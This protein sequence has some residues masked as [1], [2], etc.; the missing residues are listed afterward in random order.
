MKSSKWF[1]LLTL[2]AIFASMTFSLTVAAAPQANGS[3]NLYSA[4]LLAELKQLQQAAL[5]SE[6]AYKQVA[7]LSNNIGPR[8]TGSSQ[9]EHAVKY[10]ADEMRRLG[11]D[12]RLEKVIVPHWVRGVETGELV[13]FTGQAPSTTQKIVLTA[14]GG[15]VATRARRGNG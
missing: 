9:A 3:G 1:S 13:Q 5:A 11:L 14:L 7:H 12:V 10:V 15:S 6:Y 2:I 4:Q 8:L